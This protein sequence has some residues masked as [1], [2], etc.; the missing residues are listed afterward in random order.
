MKVGLIYT[1]STPA[2]RQYM[3]TRM[4]AILGEETQCLVLAEPE[5]LGE[6]TRTGEIPP[7]AVRRLLKLYLHAMDEGCEAILNVCSSVSPIA[8]AMD[9]LN[10]YLGAPVVSID[11]AMCAKAATMD[12][13]L[14]V[15]ATLQTAL[16]S[17]ANRI[18][19]CARRVG[20]ET[21]MTQILIEG[22]FCERNAQG[23]DSGKRS[24]PGGRCASGCILSSVNG[25][26]GRK[27]AK[28]IR[29]SC[30][31]QSGLRV[32]RDQAIENAAGKQKQIADRSH[33]QTV[34][35]RYMQLRT[36]FLH[37][38]QSV[39]EGPSESCAPCPRHRDHGRKWGRVSAIPQ[40]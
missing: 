11:A 31:Y 34:R 37:A 23:S 24:C 22:G 10:P 5:I 18:A 2:M 36:A 16:I 39:P 6:V 30:A 13:P 1:V 29:A 3:E 8:E 28:G 7:D 21:N 35:K 17:T 9:A 4:R 20:R 19:S 33:I 15:V 38:S 12:G 25:N 27:R 32:P 40:P 26:C 14:A